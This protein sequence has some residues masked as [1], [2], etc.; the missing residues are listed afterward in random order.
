MAA[1]T[2]T[3]PQTSTQLNLHLHLTFYPTWREI[4]LLFDEGGEGQGR[5][6]QRGDLRS[7]LETPFL[8]SGAEIPALSAAVKQSVAPPQATNFRAPTDIVDA[9][10]EQ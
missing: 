9:G 5:V 2:S 6:Q 1:A 8:F 10:P 7:Q 3:S 4:E